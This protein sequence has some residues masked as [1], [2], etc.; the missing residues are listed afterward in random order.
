[1]EQT[2]YIQEVQRFFPGR[3]AQVVERINDTTNPNAL[4]YLHR[5]MLRKEYSPDLKWESL[6]VSTSIVAADVIAMDSSIPL[7]KRD[8]I[9]RGKGDVPKIAMELALREKELTE[10]GILARM[11]GRTNDFIR[12]LFA[13][14]ERVIQ[15]QYETLEYMFLLGLSS[16]VTVIEDTTTNVGTGIRIDYGYLAENQFGVPVVWSNTAST[17]LS[18]I[19]NRMIDKATTDGNTI[20]LVM[21]DKVTFNRIAATTEAR[22]MYAND[23]GFFGSAAPIPTLE[24][25]NKAT[26]GKYGYIFQI[27]DRSVRFQKDGVNT[28]KK[29]WVTGAVVGLTS[30]QVGTLTWGTLAEMEH[31]SKNVNYTTVDES[32]LVSKFVLNRPSLA[33]ITNSQQLALPVINNVDSIYTM[34]SL[35]VQA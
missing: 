30:N 24:Q 6:S 14:T 28:T 34:D 21:I 27:V 4:N 15:G 5:Q 13:D 20:S 31:P 32:I 25:L 17:P 26:Q 29:P 2:L 8:S 3:A 18:D 9:A 23:S 10:L 19:N 35:T 33:E 7:K 1:M 16:G 22:N 11:P 12:R